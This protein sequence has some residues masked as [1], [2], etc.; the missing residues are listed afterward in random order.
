[1][2]CFFQLRRGRPT[3]I[4]AVVAGMREGGILRSIQEV[5][6]TGQGD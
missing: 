5:R 2:K 3:D 4:K 1:M 6:L